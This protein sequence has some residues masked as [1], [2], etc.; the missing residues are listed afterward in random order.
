MLCVLAIM[1]ATTRQTAAIRSKNMGDTVPACRV[2][3]ALLLDAFPARFRDVLDA[4]MC[5]FS[6]YYKRFRQLLKLATSYME[7]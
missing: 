3:C 1:D 7:E 5:V 6:F 2:A 4:Q